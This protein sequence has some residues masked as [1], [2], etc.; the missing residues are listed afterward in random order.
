MSAIIAYICSMDEMSQSRRTVFDG[1]LTVSQLRI[2]CSQ[3]LAQQQTARTHAPADLAVPNLAVAFQAGLW[4]YDSWRAAIELVC[5]RSY[6]VITSHNAQEAAVYSDSPDTKC[7]A[8]VRVLHPVPH[9]YSRWPVA[10][11]P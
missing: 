6:C 3:S 9:G 2:N 10:H 11:H 7:Q 5:S 8:T 1:G 4:G